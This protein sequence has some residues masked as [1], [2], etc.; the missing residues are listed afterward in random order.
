MKIFY[1][2]FFLLLFTGVG[3]TQQTIVPDADIAV[4]SWSST[5]PD[6]KFPTL[7]D[8]NDATYCNHPVSTQTT[9]QVSLGDPANTPGAGTTTIY[10]RAKGATAST[11]TVKL[12]E[13]ATERGTVGQTLTTTTTDYSFTAT[14]ITDF[15]N[16]S[17]TFLCSAKTPVVYRAYV[18]VPNA[19]SITTT[20]R[21]IQ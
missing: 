5:P 21:V 18:E 16:L 15:T 19:A 14:G 10:F 2:I 3:L 17:L 11:L 1:Y 13:G 12:L 20:I 9:L 4:N 8:N 6:D 7:A